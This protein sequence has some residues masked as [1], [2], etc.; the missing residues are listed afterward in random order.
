ME[1]LAALFFL[2]VLVAVAAVTA[3]NRKDRA[4]RQNE[5]E[6]RRT[7]GGQKPWETGPRNR[8]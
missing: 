4:L 6:N 8:P 5:I 2:L 7:P 1:I 3:A